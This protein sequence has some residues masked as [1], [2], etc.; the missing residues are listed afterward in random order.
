MTTENTGL[1]NARSASKILRR[2]EMEEERDSV[3]FTD[4]DGNEFELDVIDYFDY[5][6]EEY[7][8]LVDTE[9]CTECECEC[10]E[11]C[12][13]ECEHEHELGIYVM[14][15]I[16]NEE[17]DTEEFVPPADED[18]DALAEIVESRLDEND[19]FDE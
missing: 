16:V 9:G 10:D 18:M 12:E 17:E 19:F 11:E 7:A 2:T 13:D 6:D 14:K 8:I 15:I 3:V 1:S 5:K 4:D